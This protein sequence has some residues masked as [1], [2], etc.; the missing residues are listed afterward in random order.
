M[1]SILMREDLW[2]LVDDITVLS[3]SSSG[4]KGKFEGIESPPSPPLTSF[5]EDKLRKRRLRAKSI[6]ELYVELDMRIHIEDENDPRAAWKSL[7]A[8]FQT[9]AIADTLLILNRW[10]LLR[11]EEQMDIATFFTKVYEIRR[12]L[13]LAGHP[14]TT[15]VMVHCVLSR[16]P[17]RFKHLVQQIWSE[18]VMPTLEEL[19]TR[20]QME[21]N[22]Q[23]GERSL[24]CSDPEEV[25]VMR[26]RKVVR[27]RFSQNPQSFGNYSRI[28]GQGNYYTGR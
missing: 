11:M 22:F 23:I 25:L 24:D 3:G 6:I 20:L 17:I 14:Q 28:Q 15:G 8:L 1:K 13:Q 26:I 2:D 5:E 18:R 7:L 27:R 10:E 12:D 16:L 9:K 19:H 21:E 4:G